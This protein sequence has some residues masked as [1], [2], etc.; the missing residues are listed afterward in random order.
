VTIKAIA[1]NKYNKVS[2]MLEVKY[3]IEAKPYPLTAW[4]LKETIGSLE[5]NKTTMQEFQEA[6]GQ[7]TQ[8]DM[9]PN[10][11]FDTECRKYVYPWGYAV[12]NLAKKNWVLVELYFTDGSTFKAPRGTGI[13]DP[14]DFV[15]G[16]FKDLG[17]LPSASGNRGLYSLDSG[18][19][20][21]IWLQDDGTKILRYRIRNDGHWYILDYMIKKN[22]NVYAVDWRYTP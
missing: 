12:M 17:Q 13:S 19:D 21:K 10:G 8:A 6:Y 18:S 11:D 15:V 4:D 3:K 1:V 9:E 16:K 14:M 7:G 22:G 5:L 20:G 2:N